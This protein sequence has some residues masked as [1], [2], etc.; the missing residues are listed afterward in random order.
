MIKNKCVGAFLYGSFRCRP[1]PISASFPRSQK[2][3]GGSHFRIFK[4]LRLLCCRCT[5]HQQECAGYGG[6]RC[7]NGS[8]RGQFT[9]VFETPDRHWYDHDEHPVRGLLRTGALSEESGED[10]N[11]VGSMSLHRRTSSFEKMRALPSYLT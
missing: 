10:K 1:G 3:A 4:S 8:D 7:R 6:I 9:A 11:P 5:G 2:D